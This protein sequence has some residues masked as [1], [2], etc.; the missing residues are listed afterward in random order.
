M[1]ALELLSDLRDRGVKLWVD[2]TDLRF[3]ARKGTLGKAAAELLA[4]HK[5]EL[6]ELLKAPD[7]GATPRQDTARTK[8]FSLDDQAID[9]SSVP[10]WH[11]DEQD[12]YVRYVAPYKGFLYQRLALD[13]KFVRGEGCFLFD[14]EGTPY[15]D[16]IAQ[17]GAVPFGHDPKPIW[18]ALETVRRESRPN[19]VI[20]SI[21]AAAGELAE[22]LLTVAPA[23]LSHAVFTNSGAE[24][25]E[26]AIKLARA[27]TGRLGILSTRDG[28]HG[29]T[30]AGMS[31]TGREFFQRGFG[32]PVPGFNYV[33]FGDLEALQTTL[34]LRPDFFAAF[35]VE[36][37]QGESGIHVAPPGY[38]A[39]ATELCHRFGALLI[40]DEVQTG[41]G[42]TG[43]LFACEAEG[44]TP[45]ILTLAK[46]LGGGLMPIG[47]CLYKQSV[48]TEHFDL[49]HGSTFA[50]NALA[51][52]AAL[53]TIN[54]L[55][56][57]DRRLVRQV[58][59][60]GRRLQQQ[61]RQLQSEYPLLV[62][63][64]RGRGLMIGVDLDLEHIA[65]TQAGMLAVMQEHGLLL[66]MAVS[67]LLNVEHIRIAP[68]FT[69]GTVLRI[70][71]PLIADAALCDRL[72]ESLRRLLDI[73]QRGA[74]G[75]LLA[76]LMEGASAPTPSRLSQPKQTQ[77]P[78]SRRALTKDRTR[79]AFVVHL[80]ATSDLRRFDATLEPFSDGQLTG[81]RSRIA[82][83]VKPFPLDELAIESTDSGVADGELIVLPHL[84]SELL[85]L[86][87][88]AAVAL[89][90]SAVD[91]AS[92]RG[93]RVV[94]LGGF[95]SIVA[96]GG[97]ALT[98]RPG[99]T[100]TSGNS[101]TTWTAIR[102]VEV[103]CAKYGFAL[104][105]CTV[106]VVGATGAIGHALSLLCAERAA[107]LI[108]I[109][110]PL[111]TEASLG[112]LREVAEDC[113]RHVATR[114]A[115]GR[116][117]TPGSLAARI[118]HGRTSAPPPHGDAGMTI[119]TD[120]DQHL[121]RA[122]VVLAATN[123]VQPFI[124]SRH[125]RSG[126]LVC[127]VSRPF[128]VVPDLVQQRDDLRL[129]SG[130]L[131]LPPPSSVLGHVEAPERANALVACAAET[132]VLALSGYQSA[133]LCG[134][135]DIATIE[136]IGR[137]AEELG[138][139]VIA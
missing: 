122:H 48:Y 8:R 90:Q 81:L 31:A 69:N 86:S 101:L 75:E 50:G 109:G 51:C 104:A 107:E 88:N 70:E 80:L 119:T 98:H 99:L 4:R 26:A 56:K 132:I 1:T 23:G 133:H 12:P 62:A 47:A 59:T 53:A 38:L 43:T 124:A 83:F 61:L 100:I 6:V 9:L 39:A 116:E 94:G 92:E 19:L 49:R 97:L 111:A 2:G 32:A 7:A 121:P 55:T 113:R 123:A 139:S 20:T 79:F 84:P 41:L 126:A 127:D 52:S 44:V 108:L 106:A 13:K 21:S 112:K 110:N 11:R 91:L 37:I 95:S 93:A 17:F 136:D 129:L 103:A 22:R 125:L 65:N 33:P 77:R 71:P 120:I 72:I 85:A 40:V 68:S 34:E 115:A 135:L 25:V 3:S 66:Y 76:H 130:G 5:T 67:Y 18:D 82:E 14:A 78:I 131:V 118:A 96:D 27:R 57:D 138:F 74:A 60:V 58:S 46:A 28:F 30:L 35:V 102:S 15:A 87:G 105:D 134:R 45:D 89:V 54:E 64:I 42:R 117:F 16:F 128:N 137:L 114:V 29:L 10:D 36:I 73:L 24:A 63:D